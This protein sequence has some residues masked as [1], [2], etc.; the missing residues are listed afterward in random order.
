[1]A[2]G[3]RRVPIRQYISV[4]DALK[5]LPQ[6]FDGNKFQLIDLLDNCDS[7]FE[8][9]APEQ[10]NVLLKF[11]KARIVGAARSK[12]LVRDLTTTWSDVRATL[13][14]NYACKR[15]LDYFPCKLFAS[16]QERGES[17]AQWGSPIDAL[18]HFRKAIQ[19]VITEAELAGSIALVL[20]LGRAVL[21]QGL[22]G[23]RIKT[24]ERARGESV[25]LSEAVDI[26]ATE[27]SETASA[28]G[29]STHQDFEL[30]EPPH[31]W[32]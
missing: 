25:T 19:G 31:Y 32:I 11:I 7:A 6:P 24:I 23:D 3:R 20:K 18:H 15:T 1:M 10:H 9:V 5:L 14:E 8:L 26:A 4:S 2:L 16:R 13:V 22:Y 27:E 12:L 29:K 28:K 30:D 21:I 17:I